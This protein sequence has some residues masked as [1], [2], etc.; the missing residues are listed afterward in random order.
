MKYEQD[1]KIEIHTLFTSGIFF[2][3]LARE[4]ATASEVCHVIVMRI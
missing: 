1:Y 2:Y 4:D 3:G